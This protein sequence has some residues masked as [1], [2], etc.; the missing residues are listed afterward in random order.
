MPVYT[1]TRLERLR[2][3]RDRLNAEISAEEGAEKIRARRRDAETRARAAGQQIRLNRDA[4][5]DVV[6]AWARANGIPVGDRGRVPT[7]L[8][9]RYLTANPTPTHQGDPAA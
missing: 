2:Q 5:A 3:L 1:N 7:K 9:E 8:R 4:P 6:R